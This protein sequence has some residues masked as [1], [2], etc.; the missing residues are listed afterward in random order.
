MTLEFIGLV[1]AHEASESDAGN[2]QVVDLPFIKAFAQT[3]AYAGFDKVLLAVN[4]R[5][6]DSMI[7]ASYV[8][9]L[10]DK[11]GLLVAHRPGFQ[12]PT[13]A[14]RQFATLDQLSQGRA[15][16]NVITGGDSGDLQRDGD[17]LDKES[18]YARSGEYL[19]VM[20]Q[21]W[22]SPQ[23]FSFEGDF[24][25]V[26]DNF[27]EVKPYQKPRVPIYFSGAS[28]AAVE[29]AARHADVYMM[30]GEPLEQVKERI[31]QVRA[32]A[33]KYGREDQIRFSL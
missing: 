9:A 3:Q 8:A 13:F 12:A 10:T 27:T 31:A 32:A 29:V 25:Q 6:P 33:Q 30:W 16:I 23:P 19:E 7:I 28:D 1:G 11:L 18:R 15:A 17:F 26:R 14:A 4:T 20:K 24:Y 22:T 21:V 2:G 5:A